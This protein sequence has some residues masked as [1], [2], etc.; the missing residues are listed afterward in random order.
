MT[1]I[2]QEKTIEINLNLG[3]FW[4]FEHLAVWTLMAVRHSSF[5]VSHQ[6]QF[7]RVTYDTWDNHLERIAI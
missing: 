3:E 4:S 6:L 7:H 2:A 1:M 5:R